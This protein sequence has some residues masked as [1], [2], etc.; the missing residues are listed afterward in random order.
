MTYR[1]AVTP[2]PSDSFPGMLAQVTGGD[3]K[4]TGVYYDDSYNPQLFPAGT[5]TCTGAAPGAENADRDPSRLDAGQGLA[6][7]AGLAGS[8]LALTRDLVGPQPDASGD[9]A[10]A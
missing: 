5:T 6:G 2:F 1:N 9:V 8:I 4:T 3:P 10:A 7:L